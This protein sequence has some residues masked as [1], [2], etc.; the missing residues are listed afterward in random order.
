M[1]R[2]MVLPVR[3]FIFGRRAIV[4]PRLVRHDDF[5]DSLHGVGEGLAQKSL[6]THL[7]IMQVENFRERRAVC[8]AL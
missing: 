5:C 4:R 8:D 2:G 7:E 3:D 6:M 1:V